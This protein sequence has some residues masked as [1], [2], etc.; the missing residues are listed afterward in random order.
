MGK[1]ERQA[2]TLHAKRRKLPHLL[3]QV[4]KREEMQKSNISQYNEMSRIVG[5]M[6]NA[7]RGLQVEM[8]GRG[9]IDT[10]ASQCSQRPKQQRNPR[11]S[12]NLRGFSRQ[13]K[14]NLFDTFR[15]EGA[16]K[17]CSG[18]Y[19]GAGI[20]KILGMSLYIWGN[21]NGNCLQDMLQIV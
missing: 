6:R 4:C 11:N 3:G 19:L 8:V 1:T 21:F 5:Q 14:Y 2:K 17:C 18:R 15:P 20:I 16:G 12:E 10:A 13:E 7:V 9:F